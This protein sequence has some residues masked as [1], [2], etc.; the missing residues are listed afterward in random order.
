MLYPRTIQLYPFRRMVMCGGSSTR[1]KS[2]SAVT[3]STRTAIITG[4]GQGI[5]KAIALRLARDGFDIC[6]NDL[7]SNAAAAESVTAE[8]RSLGRKSV[9]AFANVA[10]RSDVEG[11]IERSVNELGPLS[12]MIANAGI[13]QVKPLLDATENDAQR[14]FDVNIHGVINCGTL[15]AKQFIKQGGGGKIINAAS[16]TSFKAAPMLGFYSA[17]KAAVRS[18]THT[19]AMELAMHKITVNAYAP[20][21]VDTKMW[22]QIDGAMGKYK[23]LEK[24][25]TFKGFESMIMLGRTSVPEDVCGAVSFLASKDSDYVTGHTLVCDG[26]LVFN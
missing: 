15:A 1:N 22:D 17:S 18:L 6:I 21:V 14:V 20:G 2:G 13:V 23:G 4:A 19:F 5:G 10:D 25:E 3:A 12:V 8:I 26:G 9:T 24:G 7:S 11:M 16:G